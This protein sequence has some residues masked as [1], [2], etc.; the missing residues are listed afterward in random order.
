MVNSKNIG[1]VII[2]HKRNY[3]ET[4]Y[5]DVKYL[6]IEGSP[7]NYILYYEKVQRYGMCYHCAYSEECAEYG[8]Q[9]D[10]LP[11]S[12]K[13]NDYLIKV[14]NGVVSEIY[15]GNREIRSRFRND[16]LI[17]YGC[18]QRWISKQELEDIR[19]EEEEEKRKWE[20]YERE[21]EEEFNRQL[22]ETR[23]IIIDIRDLIKDY[24]IV[25]NEVEV[26]SI[27]YE[28]IEMVEKYPISYF[29]ICICGVLG[30]LSWEDSL[31]AYN[32]ILF[33]LDRHCF[34]V[35]YGNPQSYNIIIESESADFNEQT[36]LSS[37]VQTKQEVIDLI[38]TYERNE[39]LVFHKDALIP[40]CVRLAINIRKIV[41]DYKING[42]F[43]PL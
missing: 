34:I 17:W 31:L 6:G 24:N 1:K 37:K 2:Y 40:E 22:R 20:E 26:L 11:S 36:Y 43:S 38:K 18:E 14:Q 9:C 42:L 21:L 15:D 35:N 41:P 39:L 16:N 19:Y 33:A 30:S 29:I 13:Y 12:D 23:C 3:P 32:K 10:R 7:Q 8:D 28:I 27:D 4:D 5:D 25:Q